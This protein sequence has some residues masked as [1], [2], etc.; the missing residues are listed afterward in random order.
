LKYIKYEGKHKKN[1]SHMKKNTKKAFG[2]IFKVMCDSTYSPRDTDWETLIS[3]TKNDGWNNPSA[4]FH[5]SGNS[6]DIQGTILGFHIPPSSQKNHPKFVF[7][8]NIKGLFALKFGEAKK[9]HKSDKN[10]PYWLFFFL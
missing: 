7:I 1:I 6:Q 5:S 8:K 9:Q 3:K 10:R 4:F 2:K